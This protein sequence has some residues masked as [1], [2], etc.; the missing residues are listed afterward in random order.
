MADFRNITRRVTASVINNTI[1]RVDGTD[2][3]L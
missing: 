3:E 1:K 2:D